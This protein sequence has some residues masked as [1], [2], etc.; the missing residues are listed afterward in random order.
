MAGRPGTHLDRDTAERT[1]SAYCSELRWIGLKNCSRER[2][3]AVVR[4]L[5]HR[6]PSLKTSPKGIRLVDSVRNLLP[7]DFLRSFLDDLSRSSSPQTR[8]GFGE[9]LTML[10]FG[11]AHRQWAVL[12]LDE[13]LQIYH[14]AEPPTAEPVAI[15]IA[16]AAAHGWDEPAVRPQ[17][18]RLLCQ[19]I[20]HAAGPVIDAIGTVFWAKE[21]FPADDDTE[22]LLQTLAD[23]PNSL[24]GRNVTDLVAHLAKLLPHL[25]GAVLAV[26]RA[27]LERRGAELT[28]ISHGL[29]S[30][31]PDLVSIAMTLQRFEDTKSD[32]LDLLESLLR[33][34]IDDAFAV[35][36]EVDIRPATGR[37]REPRKRRRRRGS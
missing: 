1:W 37:R 5:F 8:V 16:H 9:L 20:P 25:R 32:G 3:L 24:G 21:D 10:A 19:L 6:F 15:G 4:K 29:F 30:A 14:R 12:L 31:G 28:S 7:D 22:L 2:G 34:G 35:L 17:A 11:E 23:H 18:T 36:R 27:I 26:C 13:Q 33:L